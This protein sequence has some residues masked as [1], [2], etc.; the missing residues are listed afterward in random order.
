MRHEVAENGEIRVFKNTGVLMGVLTPNGETEATQRK[1]NGVLR[2]YC[3]RNGLLKVE[4]KGDLYSYILPLK[5]G[6]IRAG[7][8]VWV[9]WYEDLIKGRKDRIY[10]LKKNGSREILVNIGVVRWPKG[11]RYPAPALEAVTFKNAP[12]GI[13]KHLKYA[14]EKKKRKP[15]RPAKKPAEARD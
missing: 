1:F 5:V 6:A 4:Q 11:M 12:K 15:G 7:E 9:T 10:G 8:R 13:E 2:A 3:V 14:I